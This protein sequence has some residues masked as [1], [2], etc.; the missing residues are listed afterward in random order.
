LNLFDVVLLFFARKR[1]NIRLWFIVNPL[2]NQNQLNHRQEN[3]MRHL[4][5]KRR[6]ADYFKLSLAILMLCIAGP[7]FS[8]DV[9]KWV[10]QHGNTHYSDKKPNNVE[11]KSMNIRTNTPSQARKA[12][13]ERAKKLNE[14]Q[15][16][17]LEAKAQILQA[18]ARKKEV[19]SK[20]KRIRENLKTLAETSRIRVEDNGEMRYLDPEEIQKKKSRHEEQLKEFCQ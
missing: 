15:E 9:Y 5:S 18:D 11:S 14:T 12:P 3:R 7:T 4:P 19:E 13:L 1:P 16:K 6:K 2:I 10:D 8:D 20:C 17:A